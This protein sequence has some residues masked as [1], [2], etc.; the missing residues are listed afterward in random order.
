MWS[1]GIALRF[2]N[3]GARWGGWSSPSPGRFTPR[4]IP[5]THCIGGWVV[6]RTGL[7]LFIWYLYIVNPNKRKSAVKCLPVSFVLCHSVLFLCLLHCTCVCFKLWFI[8]MSNVHN[9]LK[10]YL[11]TVL[12]AVINWCHQPTCVAYRYGHSKNPPNFKLRKFGT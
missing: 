5:G 11:F 7:Y 8:Y 1:R 4:E 2:F 3:L 12:L 10:F 9:D 6:P